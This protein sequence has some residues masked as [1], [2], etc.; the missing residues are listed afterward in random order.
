MT[1]LPLVADG[2]KGLSVYSS[3][4]DL[5]TFLWPRSSRDV[6]VAPRA[7]NGPNGFHILG[8]RSFMAL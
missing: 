1:S 5:L 6:D 7:K 2:A 3:A 4:L 8:I